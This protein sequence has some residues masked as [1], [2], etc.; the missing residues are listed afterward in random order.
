MYG[1]DGESS[2]TGYYQSL[3]RTVR[4][5]CQV[6]SVDKLQEISI[7]MN[8]LPSHPPNVVHK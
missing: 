4:C 5:P 1:V 8:H 7:K 3:K 2:I 6:S